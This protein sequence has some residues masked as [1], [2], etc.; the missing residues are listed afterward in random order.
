MGGAS[1]AAGRILLGAG[2]LLNRAIQED[3]LPGTKMKTVLYQI[4]DSTA[5]GAFG[6]HGYPQNQNGDTSHNKTNNQ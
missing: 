6:I 2:S 5:L 3:I 1:T 4:G